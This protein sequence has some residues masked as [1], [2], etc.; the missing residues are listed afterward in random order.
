MRLG[1]TNSWKKA[2]R[3]VTDDQSI[4]C[5]VKW[6]G[7]LTGA[8]IEPTAATMEVQANLLDFT[9]NG[10][11][12]TDIGTYNGNSGTDA[13][14]VFADATVASVANL[15]RAINGQLAGGTAFGLTRWRASLGDFRPGFVIGAGDGLAAGPANAMLGEFAAGLN[16]VAD[17]SGLAAANTFSASIGVPTTVKGTGQS[18]PDHFQDGYTSTTAGVVTNFRE[19]VRKSEESNTPVMQVLLTAIHFGAIF[20]NNDKLVSVFDINNNLL[21]THFLAATNDVPAQ[22]LSETNPIELAPGSPAFVEGFGT[23]AL[24]DGPLT[25]HGYVRVA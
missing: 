2:S 21:F 9:V 10:G 8:G 24:T 4:L 1:S 25:I 14:I 3:T 23:G 12:E 15:V 6:V 20:A 16:V 5:R 13:Q 7:A 19:S 17:S 11:A 22:I 18:V